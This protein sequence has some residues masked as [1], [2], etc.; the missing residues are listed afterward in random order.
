M[1]KRLLEQSHSDTKILRRTTE[2]QTMK[3]R[4]KEVKFMT[5]NLK[6]LPLFVLLVLKILS[7]TRF[8]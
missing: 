6:N 5:L 4:L 1:L 3:P 8:H 7:E 2:D